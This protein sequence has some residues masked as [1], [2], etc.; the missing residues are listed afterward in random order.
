MSLQNTHWICKELATAEF[1]DVLLI[2]GYSYSKLVY[3]GVRSIAMADNGEP[4][5]Q[6]SGPNDCGF[7]WPQ[8]W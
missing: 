7:F 6:T 2:I 5:F 8:W 1:I 4:V 3:G